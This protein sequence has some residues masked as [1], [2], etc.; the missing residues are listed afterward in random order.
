M[1]GW[2]QILGSVAPS[3]ARAL[4]GPVAGMAVQAIAD[5]LGLTEATKDAVQAALE[6]AS[7]ETLLKLKELDQTFARQMAELGIEGEKVDAGDRAS[8]RALLTSTK[9]WVPGA[10]ASAVTIA[11]MGTLAV[12]LFFKIPADNQAA[13]NIM[14]GALAGAQVQVL[15]FYF[16][17]SSSSRKKDDTIQRIVE[18]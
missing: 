16:G 11:F 14:L 10:L 3:L 12:M 2:K 5:K 4:G 6:T 1:P 18:G 7:P 9:D 17:S 15:N 13:A 8:A